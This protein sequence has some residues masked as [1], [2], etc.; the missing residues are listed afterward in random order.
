MTDE[1]CEPI[2][3][4]PGIGEEVPN[5]DSMS[6]SNKIKWKFLKINRICKAKTV[7]VCGKS[8]DK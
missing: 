1:R 8:K 4:L 7:T 6:R 2:P 3:L 5:R